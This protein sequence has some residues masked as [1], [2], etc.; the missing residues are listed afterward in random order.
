MAHLAIDIFI[1]MIQMRAAGRR[2]FVTGA[3]LIRANAV[4]AVGQL[5]TAE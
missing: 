4:S 3:A 2:K 1:R 5:R